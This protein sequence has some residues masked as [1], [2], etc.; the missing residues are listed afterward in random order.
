VGES[1]EERVKWEDRSRRK[2]ASVPVVGVGDPGADP[3]FAGARLP[4]GAGRG[5]ALENLLNEGA[6]TRVIIRPEGQDGAAF[7]IKANIPGRGACYLHGKVSNVWELAR[8]IDDVIARG[9]WHS[10]KYPAKE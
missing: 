3:G 2:R 9:K 7:T 4:A 10:D 5:S 8:V 6:L 1:K